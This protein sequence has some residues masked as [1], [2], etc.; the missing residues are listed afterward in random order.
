MDPSSTEKTA[1]V[2]SSGLYQFLKMPFAL[3]NA[4][5]TFQRLMEVVLARL[6][7][8]NSVVYL[9]D[10]LVLGHRTYCQP[11]GSIAATP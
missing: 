2:T 8:K 11:T 4:P 3:V 10:I 9:D 1:F 5:A 6:A 7:R